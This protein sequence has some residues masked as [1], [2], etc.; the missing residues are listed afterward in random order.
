MTTLVISFSGG[1]TSAF[2]AVMLILAAR[3]SGQPVIVL[4]ANTGQEDPRTLDFV[5]RC[6]R[7]FSLGVIWLEAVVDPALGVGTSYVIVDYETATRPADAPGNYVAPFEQVIAKYGIPNKAFPNCNRELKLRPIY[8]YLRAIGLKDYEVA[9]GIR[10]DEVD[11]MQKDAAAN[12]IFYPLV[13]WGMVK[14]DVLAWW[15]TQSFDLYLPE[16]RGNCLL[17]WKKSW[18]KHLTLMAET[19][20]V[21]AFPERME[22][23]YPEAGAGVGVRRFFRQGKS[24]ADIRAAAAQPFVPFVDGNEAFD[25]ELDTANGNDC[26]ESCDVVWDASLMDEAA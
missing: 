2:M 13:K 26:Q 23:L 21:F 4:F 20:E 11:R 5:D 24:V 7:E 22:R 16:H 18:R 9:I 8:A 10:A 19:P 17:C 1:R 15:R 12:R 6:D 3:A 25:P 14:A